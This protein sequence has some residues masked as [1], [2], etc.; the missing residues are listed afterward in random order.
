M[1][2]LTYFF[3]FLIDGMLLTSAFP[4]TLLFFYIHVSCKYVCWHNF[5]CYC[6]VYLSW[7]NPGSALKYNMSSF[8]MCLWWHSLQ[9]CLFPVSAADFCLDR[10]SYLFETLL[11]F[12][13]IVLFSYCRRLIFL[14][15][16]AI[17]L[18]NPF[19]WI[20]FLDLGMGALQL[21]FLKY[22]F[23]SYFSTN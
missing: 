22:L 14:W 8:T 16:F 7:Q 19:F 20:A 12:F 21:L 2:Y 15:Q 5:I 4:C 9:H 18:L 10:R 23:L 13:A 3:H 17:A 1:F 11:Y 6:L